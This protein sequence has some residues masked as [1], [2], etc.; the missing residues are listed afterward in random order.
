MS[1]FKVGE[2]CVGQNFV[3]DPKYNGV[4]CV[5]DE[6]FGEYVGID[7]AGLPRRRIGYGV[8]WANGELSYVNPHNLRRKRPPTTG[9]ELIIAMFR[10]DKQPEGV[11]A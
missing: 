7:R 8:R 10:K 3:L 6:P 9:E 4:E 2:V 5:V 11:E 1:T